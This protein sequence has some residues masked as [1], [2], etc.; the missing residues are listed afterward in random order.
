LYNQYNMSCLMR[1]GFSVKDTSFYNNY[2]LTKLN[3]A[4]LFLVVVEK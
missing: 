1:F 4:H 2:D 3:L